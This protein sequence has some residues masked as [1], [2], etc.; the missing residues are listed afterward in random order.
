MKVKSAWAVAAAVCMAGSLA[1]VPAGADEGPR[2]D[3]DYRKL[4]AKA[5]KALA[6]AKP[7][8]A[9]AKARRAAACTPTTLTRTS[10]CNG[11]EITA[12]VYRRGVV[13]GTVT[14]RLAQHVSMN[15]K[16]TDFSEDISA[17]VLRAT[18]EAVGGTLTLTSDC[19]S[20]CKAAG[21]FEGVMRPGGQIDGKIS[22]SSPVGA[23]QAHAA[24]PHYT[25]TFASAGATPTTGSFE[26]LGWRCDHALRGQR[27]GC[28]YPSH[29]P[30]LTTMQQ[31][32]AIAAHIRGVQNRGPG[33]Y[34]RPG[35]GNP[36]HREADRATQDANRGA[37]CPR[38]PPVQHVGKSCDEYPF[39]AT[40]E[41]GTTL[42]TADRGIAWV[43]L[44]EQ[45]R[46]GG[47]LRTFYY[48]N[49]VLDGDAFWVQV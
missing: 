16:S 12:S 41:G 43:P 27:A 19:A 1:A 23:G 6:P 9:K 10:S 3:I 35:S 2:L 32:P 38:I 40:K 25:I 20:P 36:L 42:G 33:H 15:I 46:Q 4:S 11:G 13:T 37:V 48:A 21:R 44:L 5:F 8:S 34:G 45:R 24:R 22:Y 14:V 28:V 49:R 29:T 26:G 18:G 7:R 31:L 47:M 39:A 17:E 30:T